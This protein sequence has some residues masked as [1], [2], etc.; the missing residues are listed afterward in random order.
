MKYCYNC[1]SEIEDRVSRCPNCGGSV[2]EYAVNQRALKPGT[3]LNDK[4]LIGKVLGEGGFGITYLGL[5]LNLKIKV[6]IKEY[7]PIQCA[8]RNTFEGTSNNITII[9]GPMEKIFKKGYDDYEKEA[10]RLAAL[11]HLPGIVHVLNF[12][13]EN[14]TAYM[15]MEYVQGTTLKD[16]LKGKNNKISWKETLELMRPVIESLAIVHKS[17]IIHRDISPDNI[18]MGKDGKITLIDFGS[19]R[20]TDDDKSKTIALKHGYAPPEQYQTRGNQG[21]WTDAYAICATMY[22]MITG[23]MLPDGMAIYTGSE[24]IRMPHEFDKSLPV[25]IENAMLKGLNPKLEDRVRSMEELYAYLYEGKKIIPWKKLIT[26]VIA[27]AV[28]IVL[29][30]GVRTITK[31]SNRVKE[32]KAEEKQTEIVDDELNEVNDYSDNGEEANVDTKADTEEGEDVIVNESHESLDDTAAKYVEE[33]GLEYTTDSLISVT[34]NGTGLTVTN[35]D[36]TVSDVVIPSTISG[37]NVTEISGIGSNVT[38]LV[39][40]DTLQKIDANAFKNC[41]YLESIYIP[42]QVTSIG[43]RAFEN[44]ASL[45]DI[46]ISSSNPVFSVQD[47]KITDTDG[48]TYN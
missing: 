32:E 14:N 15:V 17:H 44:T 29:I 27:I 6:A 24:K 9:T 12:F 47:G 21:P 3:I 37:K 35:T 33:H 26:A 23:T 46:K 18:M 36:Y 34:E 19:A 13:Y 16:Y 45:S 2:N 28:V 5:D 42:A 1:M 22:R 7:F 10:R 4:F 30:I 48:K 8:T 43:D 25:E 40:P 20:E 39:L 41:V 38:S 31:F 11:E